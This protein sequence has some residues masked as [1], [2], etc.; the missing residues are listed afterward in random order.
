MSPMKETTDI[1]M[2]RY[3]VEANR[4]RLQDAFG[5]LEDKLRQQARRVEDYRYKMRAPERF[6]KRNPLAVAG[7]FSTVGF[8][9]GVRI[10]KNYAHDR[11]EGFA[12]TPA[13]GLGLEERRLTPSE[14]LVVETDYLE[15]PAF[16]RR[17]GGL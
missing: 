12:Y 14:R 10:Y 1:K 15:A 2:A 16:D 7:I 6:A 9:L 17:S 11:A 4:E 8:L 13:L 3:E 5:D